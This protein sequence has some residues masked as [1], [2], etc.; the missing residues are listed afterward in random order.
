MT[1]FLV[2]AG[3]G[4]LTLAAASLTLPRVLGWRAETAKLRPLTREVFWTYAAS[5]FSFNVSFR[6]VLALEPG[7]PP[8]ARPFAR[9]VCGFIAVSWGVRLSIQFASFGRHAPPGPLGIPAHEPFRVKTR[10]RRAAAAQFGSR[11]GPSPETAHE[12]EDQ[13]CRRALS[14]GRATTT[15]FTWPSFSAYRS[16]G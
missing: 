5:I 9:A 12:P 14:S 10:E 3:L 7:W 15:S 1:P 4:Q 6:L 2:A 8:D 13:A 16:P 11:H